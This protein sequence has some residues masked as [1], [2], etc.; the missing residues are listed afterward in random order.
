M[1]CQVIWL[2]WDTFQNRLKKIF[3]LRHKDIYTDHQRIGRRLFSS[4]KYSALVWQPVGYET[5]WRGVRH[6]PKT[7]QHFLRKRCLD[8]QCFNKWWWWYRMYCVPWWFI[9]LC[10]FVAHDPLNSTQ[11]GNTCDSHAFE[12]T[13]ECV[14]WRL[15]DRCMTSLKPKV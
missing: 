9:M 6:G 15:T 1:I 7:N 11:S 5:P 10:D 4:S 13:R 14:Y 12:E 2:S 8:L 3:S